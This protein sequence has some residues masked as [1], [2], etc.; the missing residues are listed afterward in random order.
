MLQ[1]QNSAVRARALRPGAGRLA[2]MPCAVL[3]AAL[4]TPPAQAGRTDSD[5]MAPAARAPLVDAPG[6]LERLDA[7]PGA[8]R[9][10]IVDSMRIATHAEA[11]ALMQGGGLLGGADAGAGAGTATLSALLDRLRTTLPQPTGL[12]SK[13]HG[14]AEAA[15]AELDCALFAE[16][17]R[18]R[19]LLGASDA[20]KP[21][22]SAGPASAMGLDVPIRCLT[23]VRRA[24]SPARAPQAVPAAADRVEEGAGLLRKPATLAWLRAHS[25]WLLML[26]ASAVLT[27][28]LGLAARARARDQA[29]GHQ[30]Q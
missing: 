6:G 19:R 16:N 4:C 10:A 28:V 13:I 11:Q 2:L 29:N 3:C 8:T 26:A 5:W 1:P 24:E 12:I 15:N 30:W 14:T 27:A 22:E 17:V 20:H 23:A 18:V 21:S 9:A 7:G 25:D